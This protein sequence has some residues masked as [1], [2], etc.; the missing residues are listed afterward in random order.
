MD[1]AGH[2][3][4]VDLL[5]LESESGEYLLTGQDGA[6]FHVPVGQEEV[7]LHVRGVLELE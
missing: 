6:Y 3:K 2:C 5:F 7:E 4:T 1:L